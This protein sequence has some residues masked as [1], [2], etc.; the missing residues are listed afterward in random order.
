MCTYIIKH[1]QNISR[2][3]AWTRWR[4]LNSVIPQLLY[5]HFAIFLTTIPQHNCD[6]LFLLHLINPI[7][8]LKGVLI[9]LFLGNRP[10]RDKKWQRM[11]MK[12]NNSFSLQKFKVQE[13]KCIIRRKL[14]WDINGI[15]P[16]N[17]RYIPVTKMGGKKTSG[18]PVGLAHHFEVSKQLGAYSTDHMCLASVHHTLNETSV[19]CLVCGDSYVQISQNHKLHIHQ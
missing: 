10:W 7:F 2:S 19:E 6:H 5:L 13:I 14:W 11:T 18:G 3:L 1:H 4:K 16:L 8:H 17:K 9:Q 15:K 12:R